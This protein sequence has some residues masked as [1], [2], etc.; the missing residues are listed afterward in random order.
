MSLNRN[1]T[2]LLSTIGVCLFTFSL[3]ARGGAEDAAARGLA[4]RDFGT[5]LLYQWGTG[6]YPSTEWLGQELS[7]P[8]PDSRRAVTN[9]EAILSRALDGYGADALAIRGRIPLDINPQCLLGLC[10]AERFSGTRLGDWGGR[11]FDRCI[12][13][14]CRVALPGA[15]D[16]WRARLA[17]ELSA[18]GETSGGP[19]A[20]G[21]W[22]GTEMPY[23]YLYLLRNA[24]T[25][26]IRNGWRERLAR[27]LR[28]EYGLEPGLRE[29]LILFDEGGTVNSTW[30]E[31]AAQLEQTGAPGR[32]EHVYERILRNADSR[33]DA[34]TAYEN[35]AH[36]LLR[37]S[38]YGQ[39]L[40]AWG[41]LLQR[42]PSVECIASDIRD[43]VHDFQVNRVQT[44]RQ[45]WSELARMTSGPQ[46]LQWC[47]RFEALWQ[48]EEAPSQWQAATEK[49]EPGSLARQLGRV[50][51]A[52]ALL[53]AGRVD[54]AETLIREYTESSNPFV[55][56]RSLAVAAEIARTRNNMEE[57]VRQYARAVQ[58]DRQTPL[59]SWYKELVQVPPAGAQTTAAEL[60]AQRLFLK[61]CNLLIEGDYAGAVDS[62]QQ[63]A[64][65]R[66]LPEAQRRA[67]PGVTML[68]CLGLED[69]AQ[70][71]AW[72]YQALEARRADRPDEAQTLE[73]LARSQSIDA[74][75]SQLTATI[76]NP[77]VDPAAVGAAL[78]DII[79][80]CTT[81]TNL[82]PSESRTE[83]I[84]SGMLQLYVRA[85][86]R[87]LARVLTAEYLGVREHETRDE[88]K[89][90]SSALLP[91][92]FGAQVLSED[93]FERIRERFSSL[94]QAQDTPGQ[95]C[96]F[97]A[98]AQSL[99]RMDLAQSALDA[100]AASAA[101]PE[102]LGEIAGMYL[103]TSHPQKAID[104]YEKVCTRA[105][106]PGRARAALLRIIDLY[107]ENLKNYDKAVQKCEEFVQKYPDSPEASEVEFLLGKYAY[108]RKD[109]AGAVGQLDGFQKK[110][111]EHP[112]VGP[113]L[114]L[115]ALSRLAEGNTAEAI[116]R[117]REIIRR[118]P[119]SDLAARSKFLT[120][121]AQVS[122]Q[123][124]AAAM[125]TFRQLIEQFP[126]SPYVPQ[127]QNL[128]ERLRKVSP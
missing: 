108:L 101:H 12:E 118:Y 1:R 32:A 42:F 97:A 57:A 114:M 34:R 21:V 28:Q 92:F 33:E 76:R 120:G 8:D 111:P 83:G 14:A 5:L 96:R 13:Q 98:F 104:V 41:L 46:A 112:Q 49:T 106:D 16:T 81:G 74:L 7:A 4:W 128:L 6:S 48:P 22:A 15:G 25:A 9:A 82:G 38:R 30:L 103:A 107:A 70:A 99:K 94:G 87:H 110:Y 31:V 51:L 102:A 29:Y 10:L 115:A 127:A 40:Q 53:D 79:D 91:L 88:T 62:L 89:G 68:A 71:E 3:T 113:A 11:Q 56:A 85:Q 43:F 66:Q 17:T 125:E 67:L 23:L 55:Q 54:T 80:L 58:I 65:L 18:A 69:Y 35:L 39:A 47:R 50:F 121:Y 93:S 2:C 86:K 45:L 19:A 119:D 63:A 36:I 117:F 77:V 60:P 61:G 116:G 100:G 64:D 72:G 75:F 123:Q 37:E 44:G 122:A 26:D 52:G 20:T 124:Y 90:R 84:D 24:R 109:Y 27:S 59:P 78:R 73:L 105:K 95:M 126:Q